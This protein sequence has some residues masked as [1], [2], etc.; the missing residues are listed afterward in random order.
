MAGPEER[1]TSCV[2]ESLGPAFASRT[3]AKQTMTPARD[4]ALRAIRQALQ[5]TEDG[6]INWDESGTCTFEA[7]RSAY[8][9]LMPPAD[10]PDPK[11]RRRLLDK[12]RKN[13]D[14][15]RTWLIAE[16]IVTPVDVSGTA[17]YRL[18]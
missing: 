10:D 4:A 6:G 18:A 13:F 9:A 16:N 14:N 17:Q 7:W 1:D 11:E 5:D 12:A 2:V 8:M 3:S 15:A